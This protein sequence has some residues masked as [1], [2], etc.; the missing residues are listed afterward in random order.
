MSDGFSFFKELKKN[1][2]QYSILDRDEDETSTSSSSGSSSSS[3][4]SSDDEDLNLKYKFQKSGAQ[5]QRIYQNPGGNS[6]YSKLINDDYSFIDYKNIA[7]TSWFQTIVIL[8]L[9]YIL[10]SILGVSIA[11]IVENQ[12]VLDNINYAVSKIGTCNQ[13]EQ[14]T[15]QNEK[16][17]VGR[18]SGNQ[19][20]I[21]DAKDST[22][23]R[24]NHKY[25]SSS[26]GR[27]VWLT[28]QNE[29]WIPNS[30]NNSIDVYQS[31]T[32]TLLTSFTTIG[33]TFQCHSPFWTSYHPLAGNLK[34]GQVWVS[35]TSDVLGWAVF[36][37]NTYTFVT[38]IE[39]STL[40]GPFV[41][42]DIAVGEFFTVVSLK[43]T[44]A[45]G[46]SNLIQYNNNNFLPVTISSSVGH[47]PLLS[48]SGN[49]DSFLYVTSFYA[50]EAYKINF[51]SLSIEHTWTSI[52]DAYGITT[53]PTDSYVYITEIS[54]S[55]IHIYETYSPYNE[56]SFSP[57]T[58][59]LSNPLMIK[60]DI[61]GNKLY[62]TNNSTDSMTSVYNI[63]SQD[64]TLLFVENIPTGNG[65]YFLTNN[66]I[67]CVCELCNY[68]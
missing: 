67:N 56:L 64:K 30:L 7:K 28:A 44:S 3:S 4:S 62:I 52:P 13:Q 37:P 55:S 66:A 1:Q 5:K 27:P 20:S 46:N 16:I 39:L 14:N 41:P 21:I 15:F 35:C 10:L 54:S 53:D 47:W 58:S 61:N 18:I 65:S 50:Q 26:S 42:Y 19:T 68:F 12:K 8:S 24:L 2:S 22:Q 17:Y 57:V 59:N 33:S 23:L 45:V 29:M 43:N 31:T 63:Q 48:Y 60:T 36:D 40:L 11:G 49:A 6:D 51:T 38:F 25:T 9:F 32:M 34:T